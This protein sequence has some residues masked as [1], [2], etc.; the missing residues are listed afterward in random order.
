MENLDAFKDEDY[1]TSSE[2]ELSDDNDLYETMV[3]C[4]MVPDEDVK[5]KEMVK[6]KEHARGISKLVKA[7]CKVSKAEEL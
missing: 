2:D 3:D 7:M 5:F 4:D 1:L 6:N